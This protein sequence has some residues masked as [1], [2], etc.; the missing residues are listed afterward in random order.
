M[1]INNDLHLEKKTKKKNETMTSVMNSVHE[2]S[3][4]II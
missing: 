3:T 4:I 1:K 2:K